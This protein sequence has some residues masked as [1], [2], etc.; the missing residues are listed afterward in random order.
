MFMVTGPA[1]VQETCKAARIGVLPRQNVRPFDRF[2]AWLKEI[3]TS[4]D[5][6]QETHPNTKF[7]P[8]G[9]NLPNSLGN[10]CGTNSRV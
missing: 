9:V 8:L 6:H 4:L 7:G 2:E 3:R 10:P 1:M 5:T